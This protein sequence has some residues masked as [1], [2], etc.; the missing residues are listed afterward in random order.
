MCS[1]WASGLEKVKIFEASL[2]SDIRLRLKGKETFVAQ[3]CFWE[4]K[5]YFSFRLD[6][7]NWSRMQKFILTL[8]S[9]CNFSIRY[10]FIHVAKP[11]RYFCAVISHSFLCT[12]PAL[13]SSSCVWAWA[14]SPPSRT[15]SSRWRSRT[16]SSTSRSSSW[17]GSASSSSSGIFGGGNVIVYRV[18][19]LA[20]LQLHLL[21]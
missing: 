5:P 8:T 9:S 10:T 20:T 18:G 2:C 4:R 16:P 1:M 19:D 6:F 7:R 14:C 17:S 11:F 13:W 12:R 3:T 21:S 15:T